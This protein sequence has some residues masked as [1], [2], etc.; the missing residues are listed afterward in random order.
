[1]IQISII[2]TEGLSDDPECSLKLDNT[3]LVDTK[4]GS[5]PM[6]TIKS[7]G[8]LALTCK[9]P[10][11]KLEYFTSFPSTLL[12]SEGFQWI[13]LSKLS[14]QYYTSFPEEV[15]SPKVLIMISADFLPQIDEI[16]ESECEYCEVLKKE[17]Q[18]LKTENL[19][20]AKEAK[21]SFDLLTAESEKNKLLVKKFSGLYGECRKEL[22]FYK[23]KFE[24]ERRKCSEVGEKLKNLSCALGGFR[25]KENEFKK[26]ARPASTSP[27]L[28]E[29]SETYLKSSLSQTK[30]T[31]TRKP[32]GEIYNSQKS[33]KDTDLALRRYLLKTNRKGLITKDQGN[34][35]KIG[36]KKVSITLKQ[37]NLLC[38]VGG[39][40]EG[41]EEYIE[42]NRQG[43]RSGSQL[44][45]RRQFTF[46]SIRKQTEGDDKELG[47]LKN[48]PVL[49]NQLKPRIRPRSTSFPECI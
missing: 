31:I 1:M 22:E 17:I 42:K 26:V 20:M 36:N 40:F 15:P 43:C 29:N 39:G 49:E 41:I 44:N 47:I 3:L 35:Y 14:D 28:F 5:E 4:T 23:V 18:K 24:E 37:G 19:R 21:N 11:K 2:R 27:V 9:F 38:R 6:F 12:P 25:G 32:L 13:P 16:S 48:S 46:D 8:T 10:L 30:L 33:F 34:N 45:H 7:A